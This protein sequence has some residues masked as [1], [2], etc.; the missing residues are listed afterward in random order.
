MTCVASP[1][2]ILLHREGVI[3]RYDKCGFTVTGV[4]W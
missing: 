3:L 1:R 4:A 2:E